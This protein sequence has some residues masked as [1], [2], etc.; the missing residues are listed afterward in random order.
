LLLAR[1][2]HLHK[3][4]GDV[5]YPT[6][7]CKAPVYHQSSGV[8]V[9]ANGQATFEDTFLA[10]RRRDTDRHWPDSRQRRRL[11]R[12]HGDSAL[13]PRSKGPVMTQRGPW[14]RFAGWQV[15]T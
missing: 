11:A 15:H 7:L 3:N 9:R 8:R 10:D 14:I 5:I 13:Q 1:S 2:P 12:V 6:S 4:F